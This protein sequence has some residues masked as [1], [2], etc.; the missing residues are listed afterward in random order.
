[1]FWF[2]GVRGVYRMRKMG[3]VT[4]MCKLYA[5]V[6]SRRWV[7]G[8]AYLMLAARLPTSIPLCLH[9]AIFTHN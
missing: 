7:C 2:G 3:E 1:M 5:L 6:T 8:I 9:E 4:F